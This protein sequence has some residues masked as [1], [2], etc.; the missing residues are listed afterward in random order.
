MMMVD[1]TGKPARKTPNVMDTGWDL[2]TGEE[3]KQVMARNLR[4]PEHHH[5]C[6]RNVATSRFLISSYEG[7][8]FL[9]LAGDDNVQNNWIRGACRTG[10]M[11]GN[12][13][14]YVP[15]DQCF[16]NPGSKLLGYTALTADPIDVRETGTAALRL[17]KGPAFGAITAPAT[18]AK[19]DW[20]T[21]RHDP[22]RHGTTAAAVDGPIHERWQTQLGGRLSA[23]V[24][25]DGRLYVA[26]IDAHT[27]WALDQRDG[28]RLW[29][30]VAEGRVDS[31][32]TIFQGR[33]LFGS[34]DG[35]V[36]CLRAADGA[37]AWRFRAAPVDHRIAVFDQFEST[38][39]VFG[40]VLIAHDL[41]YVT[42]GRS[43]YLD[44]GI[45]VYALAPATGTVVHQC[46]LTGPFPNSPD[47]RDFGF[48][49]P[50]ALA[51]VLVAEGGFIYMRQR[52]LTPEL[53][54]VE[55]P[56]LSSK[57]A[58]DVGLHVF[59]TASMLDGS[60]YNRTFWMYSKRWPGF[61]LANQAPKT[62]Q[63][64]VVD[65]ENTY[66]VRVFYR[67]NV[68]S[69]MFFPGKEGYLLFADANTTEPQI[70]GEQGARP[71][72]RWLPQSDYA[73]GRGNEMRAL[74][75]PAFGLDKMIGYTRADPPLWMQWI[76]VRMRAMVKAGDQLFVAGP[77]DVYDT[78][79]PFAPFEGRDGARLL[80]VSTRD[81]Q[82]QASLALN[83]PPVFDGMIAAGG[84]LFVTLEN[85]RVVC[86]GKE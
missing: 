68:H 1:G 28:R 54:E 72:L 20:P 74:D 84:R 22:A 8:E 76:N 50:G 66:A 51:E 56:V 70:V 7:A 33:V 17:Q 48:Y 40:S 14:L 86:L 81:G 71:P 41:A 39:P 77:P 6:Y 15:P 60:W 46:T 5:R 52:K 61:Q 12:G 45:R 59:S 16:C 42:A 82:R 4:S 25:A 80:T 31:P 30:F 55:V 79:D 26:Q 18:V 9:D 58:Q 21:F 24:A 19:S 67:R 57:G 75:S 63:L 44:G 2:R 38:W 32:P 78:A 34:R 62:G 3:V 49:S 47:T 36:Y 13:M 23:P 53:E 35:Y 64:L 43:T 37:L 11:P 10:M 27:V 69:P 73:R 29:Q 85:G 83:S 65:D